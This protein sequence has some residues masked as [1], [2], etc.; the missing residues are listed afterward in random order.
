MIAWSKG[1]GPDRLSGNFAVGLGGQNLTRREAFEPSSSD[2]AGLGH[3][4]PRPARVGLAR[5]RAAMTLPST[6]LRHWSS[7]LKPRSSPTRGCGIRERFGAMFRR[8]GPERAH[9]FPW[10]QWLCYRGRERP[11]ASARWAAGNEAAKAGASGKEAAPLVYGLDRLESRATG[12]KPVVF[13]PEVS[14]LATGS[15][16][17]KEPAGQYADA[18]RLGS[19]VTDCFTH[20][21]RLHGLTVLPISPRSSPSELAR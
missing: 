16:W 4:T 7:P 3:V 12:K 10:A 5:R 6:R 15:F 13:L 18:R 11:I 1:H 19:L 9:L 2:W 20:L 17:A 14:T 21:A 8:A